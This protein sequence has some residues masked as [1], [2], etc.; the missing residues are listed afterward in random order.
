M[1]FKAIGLNTFVEYVEN[2][3][4]TLGEVLY[5]I[6][7]NPISGIEKISDLKSMS[8][9]DIYTIIE[10]ARNAEESDEPFIKQ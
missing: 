5:S 3:E 4:Y 6:L 2:T 10:K 7:R 8:D 1:N 9:E